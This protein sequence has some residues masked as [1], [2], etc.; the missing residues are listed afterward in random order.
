MNGDTHVGIA[1]VFGTSDLAALILSVGLFLVMI[2]SVVAS[3]D[4]WLCFSFSWVLTIS[5]MAN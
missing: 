3:L 1:L 2:E 4:A 5:P